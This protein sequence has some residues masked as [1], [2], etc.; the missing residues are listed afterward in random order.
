MNIP[1]LNIKRVVIIGAG[2]AGLN[3]AKKLNNKGLQVVL[4]DKNNYHTFQPLLYQ[5]A[6]AGLE[7]DSI[8]HAVRTLFKK[9]KNFHFRIAEIKEIDS[10]NKQIKSDIGNLKYDL[11]VIA[12]GSNTNYY[13]NKNI[14]KYAV[15]MKSI[16]EALDLR[17]LVL[18]NLEAAL[19]TN[20]LE[21]RQRLM[22]FVIVG[23]GPTGVELAGAFSELK[24]HVL[25]NDYPDLDINR[26]NVHLI[27]AADKLLPGFSEKASKT[28]EEY[29]RK[30]DVNIW[31][32]TQV[33]DYDG[34]TVE[35]NQNNFKTSTLIW[36]AGV[37]GNIVKGLPE[38]SI[39]RG[40][41]RVD[42][43]NRIKGVD[44]IFAIGDIAEMES[45]EWPKGHPMVAQ[46]AIQQGRLLGENIL[47]WRNGEEMKPFKYKDKGSMATIGR[48]K[49][50]ADIGKFKFTGFFAWIIWMF[51][52]LISLVGFRN[53][54][55]AL[56]NWVIQYFQYNKGVRLIIRPYKNKRAEQESEGE[57]I[58][59]QI[60]K[61]KEK[62][63]NIKS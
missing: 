43:F 7:A 28:A 27:Q 11:L 22:N 57:V 35:T 37:K 17:H 44:S 12:T 21:E 60:L 4:I 56:V 58:A 47:K 33:K 38:D 51:V 63:Y 50:V 31:L 18:Q 34:E 9:G 40:R 23:G 1:N 8:A 14:E 46:P 45:N 53:K 41:Y 30:M 6:T 52:H 3:L 29:L 42:E 25:P 49:A 26:M 2:F 55:V 24:N 10:Q 5:V 39:N 32:N 13:G 54:V 20:D 19:L 15:P 48:N 16:P 36:A 62:N 59:D 61:D